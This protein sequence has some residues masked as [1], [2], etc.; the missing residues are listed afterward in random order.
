M[1]TDTVKGYYG[2]GNTNCLIFTAEDR[3]GNTWYVVEGGKTVN[4]TADPI[5]LGCNVEELSD[6]D[7][8]TWNK[9]IE[10]EEELEEAIDY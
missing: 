4:L 10:S 9:G 6:I 2:S 8:F 3:S 5:N 7:C 1:R